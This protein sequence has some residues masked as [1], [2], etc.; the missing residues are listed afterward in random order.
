MTSSEP[1]KNIWNT[2]VPIMLILLIVF[3]GGLSFWFWSYIEAERGYTLH[4]EELNE[5]VVHQGNFGA[6]IISLSDKDFQVIPKLA[7]IIRDNTQKSFTINEK[8]NRLYLL[9]ITDDERSEFIN[10]FGCCGKKIFEYN[11]NY[12]SYSPP[13]LH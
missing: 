7:P 10:K 6:D 8:G 4:L 2:V 1:K 13:P 11:G 12:Y 5:S 3:I 9:K